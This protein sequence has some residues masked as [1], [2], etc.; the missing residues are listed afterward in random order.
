MCSTKFSIDDYK[1][2]KEIYKLFGCKKI[3]DYN[4]LYVKTNV[5]LLA[6]A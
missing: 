2:A 4:D 6:D 3:K 5:L 1:Y